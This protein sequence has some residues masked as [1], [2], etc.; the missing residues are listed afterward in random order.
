MAMTI[1]IT[2]LLMVMMNANFLL[3]LFSSP[4]SLFHPL[5][6]KLHQQ[7]AGP[8][9]HHNHECRDDDDDD[10][11]KC[12]P[13]DVDLLSPWLSTRL[14]SKSF[15]DASNSSNCKVLQSG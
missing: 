10:D 15:L 4:L 8:D 7:L 13:D 9:H 12:N 3:K 1:T 2:K 11:G 14:A 5:C 6:Q